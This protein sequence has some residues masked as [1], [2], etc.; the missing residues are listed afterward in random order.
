M[1][2]AANYEIGKLGLGAGYS[3]LGDQNQFAVRASYSTGPF[4]MGAYVQRDKN[5]FI[6]N[7]GNR[8]NLRLSAAYIMGVSE[9]HVNVG[10]AGNYSNVSNSAA[11]QYTLGYNYNLSKRTKI[12]TYYTRINNSQ[13]ATYGVSAPGNDFSSFAVGVRHNF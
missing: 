5:V 8:T 11:T 6:A 1:D 12:Y 4:V 3:K 10:R 7:G 2:L 13:A 9:F